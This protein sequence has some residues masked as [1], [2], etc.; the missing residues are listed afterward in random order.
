MATP[1]LNETHAGAKSE[2]YVIRHITMVLELLDSV[3]ISGVDPFQLRMKAFPLS[4]MKDA[5]KWWKN[6][7]DGLHTVYP[8]VWDT[9]LAVNEI[10]LLVYSENHLVL[11]SLGH[12]EDLINTLFAQLLNNGEPSKC[13]GDVV[14]FRTWPGISL[15]T[16]M[17]STIDLDGVTCLTVN[18]AERLQLLQ[19]FLLLEG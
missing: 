12:S 10:N 15:K 19:E 4:L 7:G 17:M 18:A 16:L 13:V 1:T 2:E 11:T 3:N 8:R 9:D 14:E 5:R 6:V